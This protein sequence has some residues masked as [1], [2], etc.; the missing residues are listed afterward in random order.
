MATLATTPPPSTLQQQA[1]GFVNE[2]AGVATPQSGIDTKK[3]AAVRRHRRSG[4]HQATAL[5]EIRAAT[6]PAG[7]GT[8]NPTATR[9]DV[10]GFDRR[11]RAP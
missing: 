10:A 8:L 1:M 4:D 7:T 9:P 11:P 2:F 3:A 5:A 6:T